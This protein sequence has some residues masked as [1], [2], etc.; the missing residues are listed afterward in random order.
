MG[1]RIIG[2]WNSVKDEDYKRGLTLCP[3]VLLL[4]D[5]DLGRKTRGFGLGREVGVLGYGYRRSRDW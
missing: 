2:G 5:D 4:K 1:V 3:I